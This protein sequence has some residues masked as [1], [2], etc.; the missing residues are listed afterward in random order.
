MTGITLVFNDLSHPCFHSQLEGGV[1]RSP[2]CPDIDRRVYGFCV[3][4]H[5]TEVR[6]SGKR[7]KPFLSSPPP[8]YR[9]RPCRGL[10]GGALASEYRSQD[11]SPRSSVCP[12]VCP[13]LSHV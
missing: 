9:S 6:P 3:I 7:S 1:F 13:L 12:S 11:P 2:H 10:V 5:L 4:R 8:V